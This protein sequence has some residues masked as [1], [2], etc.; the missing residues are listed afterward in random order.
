M[1]TYVFIIKDRQAYYIA[2]PFAMSTY[3]V[4]A[5]L[6]PCNVAPEMLCGNMWSVIPLLFGRKKLLVWNRNLYF[7]LNV[8]SAVNEGYELGD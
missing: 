6:P 3:D 1:M 5:T 4:G 7:S 2:T 8:I